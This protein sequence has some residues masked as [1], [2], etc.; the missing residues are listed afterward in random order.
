MKKI[1]SIIFSVIFIVLFCSPFAYAQNN[2][3]RRDLVRALSSNDVPAVEKIISDHAERI[4][5]SEKRLMYAF[6][7][8]YSHRNSTMTILRLLQNHNIHPAVFDLFNALNRAHSDE[9]IQ[10][11]LSQGTRPNGEILLFAAEKKRFNLVN[12]FAEMGADVNYIYPDGKD[13]SNGMTALLYAVQEGN[14]ETVKLLIEKGA[15]INAPDYNGYTPAS[16]AKRMELEEIYAYL[17]EHGADDV[18]IPQAAAETPRDDTHNNAAENSEQ[19]MASLMDNRQITLKGGTYRLAGS[20]AEIIIPGNTS[21]GAF[22]Y[23]RQGI[24]RMGSFRIDNNTIIIMME[25]RTLTY[26][27]DSESS[28]SGYGER[29]VWTRN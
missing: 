11:I 19:G 9:V 27:I 28:F 8:D 16:L 23:T 6:A 24:P 7:L 22:S 1:F 3:Y 4:P 21:I 14:F 15:D 13:Y 5:E 25:T 17:I 10:Y 29:W 20:S 18:E 2:N 12:Q 26:N